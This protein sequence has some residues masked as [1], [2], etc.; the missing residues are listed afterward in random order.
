MDFRPIIFKKGRKKIFSSILSTKL[1]A[2]VELEKKDKSIFYRI[3]FHIFL[4]DLE[5][6]YIRWFFFNDWKIANKSPKYC[7][8]VRKYALKPLLEGS[9]GIQ[10]TQGQNQSAKSPFSILPV[11]N[12]EQNPY[13]EHPSCAFVYTKA[14]H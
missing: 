13:S 9:S 1:K 6:L 4:G 14:I 11:Y 8:V 10:H 2:L 7:D 5:I 3:I 12:D